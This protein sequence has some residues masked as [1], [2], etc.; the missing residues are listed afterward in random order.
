MK[1]SRKD[2]E[3][4]PPWVPEVIPFPNIKQSLTQSPFSRW[5]LKSRSS[6]LPAS[7]RAKAPPDFIQNWASCPRNQGGTGKDSGNL[8]HPHYLQFPTSARGDSI[9]LSVCAGKGQSRDQT[10]LCGDKRNRQEPMPR[11]LHLNMKNFFTVWDCPRRSHTSLTGGIPELSGHKP[12]PRA[13]G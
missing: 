13:Q 3:K 8:F 1:Q 7:S 6:V 9:P 4:H 5:R 2:T 10:L 11:K 12:V